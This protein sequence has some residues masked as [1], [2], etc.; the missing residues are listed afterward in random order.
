MRRQAEEA[1]I[2]GIQNF[3]KDLL[4]VAD[5]LHLAVETVPQ[6]KVKSADDIFKN[7]F[8]GVQM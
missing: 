7:L 2:Y 4:D 8:E 6:E 1:K 3:C 5:V